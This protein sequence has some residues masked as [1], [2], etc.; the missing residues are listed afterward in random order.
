MTFIRD[1]TYWLMSTQIRGS[2]EKVAKGIP[3]IFFNVFEQNSKF[4][5]LCVAM[6]YLN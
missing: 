3:E 2:R 5:T 1:Q 4:L 6:G